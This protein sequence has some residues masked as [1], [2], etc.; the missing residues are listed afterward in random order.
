MIVESDVFERVLIEQ[1]HA[2]RGIHLVPQ[3]EMDTMDEA[4]SETVDCDESFAVAAVGYEHDSDV[5]VVNESLFHSSSD[6]HLFLHLVIYGKR[7]DVESFELLA[8]G[9]YVVRVAFAAVLGVAVPLQ[10]EWTAL[11]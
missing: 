9:S 2:L 10:L 3:L 6:D 1:F 4:H 8:V 5:F 7:L 11:H